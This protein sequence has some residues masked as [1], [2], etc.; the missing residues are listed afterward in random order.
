MAAC[1]MVT[2][3]VLFRRCLCGASVSSALASFHAPMADYIPSCHEGVGKSSLK[4]GSGFLV[5]SALL[6]S[7]PSCM[8]K[9]VNLA[10]KNSTRLP[11]ADSPAWFR[12]MMNHLRQQ[13]FR[14]LPQMTRNASGKMGSRTGLLICGYFCGVSA[15][16]ASSPF[17][18]ISSLYYAT[19]QYSGPWLRTRGFGR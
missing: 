10:S 18:H 6:Y 2:G 11:K 13:T 8:V 12:M 14:S 5:V 15:F 16:R 7:S 19:Y 1:H 4:K 17:A 3:L 9:A